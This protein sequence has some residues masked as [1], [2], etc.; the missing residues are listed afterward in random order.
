MKKNILNKNINIIV[1]RVIH[2]NKLCNSRPCYNC[3]NMMKAVGINKIYYTTDN[4]D[5]ICER[6]KDMVSIQASHVIQLISSLKTH[7][8]I[9]R[10][11]YFEIL[12]HKLFPKY[13]KKINF[14]YF[15][16][17]NLINVLPFYTFIIKNNNITLINKNLDCIITAILI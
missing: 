3:L 1:V 8:E 10:E 16:K 2:G 5:I 7:K 9:S 6:I 11:T 14:E 13:I 12:L 4:G 17:Y 15:Y